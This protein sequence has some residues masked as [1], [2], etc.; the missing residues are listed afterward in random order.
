MLQ[1]RLHTGGHCGV[2]QV[3]PVEEPVVAGSLELLKHRPLYDLLRETPGSTALVRVRGCHE[4]LR[5]PDG[6]EDPGL[7]LPGH[8]HQV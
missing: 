5:A 4:V 2:C 3:S 1:G 7:V 8:P 6:G